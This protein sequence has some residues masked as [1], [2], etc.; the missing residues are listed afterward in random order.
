[1][2]NRPTIY[3]TERPHEVLTNMTPKHILIC[4]SKLPT[5]Q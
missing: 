1:M 2:V 4:L 3:N 5:R